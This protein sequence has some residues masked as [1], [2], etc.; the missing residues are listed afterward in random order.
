MIE[1]VDYST[2][3]PSARGLAAI[4]KEFA[5][6]YVGPGTLDKLLLPTEVAQLQAAGLW[7]VS[8]V[9]GFA[10]DAL[11]GY[12]KGQAHAE[13]AREWH[14][15]H[16]YRWPVPCYFAVDFDVQAA[17]WGAVREYFQGAASII[18]LSYTGIYGGLNA[19]RWAHADDVARWFF[20]TSAWSGGTWFPGNH[21]EQ[22]RNDVSLVGGLVDLDRAPQPLYGGW[23]MSTPE[24]ASNVSTDEIFAVQTAVAAGL[25]RATMKGS[26]LD[27]DLSP[28]WAR[29]PRDTVQAIV[30]AISSGSLNFV[31]TITAAIQSLSVQIEALS[32]DLASSS[33]ASPVD[34]QSIATALAA[35]LDFVSALATAVSAKLAGLQGEI[36]LAGPVVLTPKPSP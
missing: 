21:L 17:Q 18:G 6:R 14:L 25:D 22:Y 34:A 35:D 23:T 5:A 11:L 32:G 12:A 33:L 27:V 24:P 8:L 20:Q 31:N 26:P 30:D 1:G 9:E 36:T 29:G 13:Q 16:N 4:G 2:V 10:D 7:I 15:E 3:H 28:Y 19:M